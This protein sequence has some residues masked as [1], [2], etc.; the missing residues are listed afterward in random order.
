MY[1]C[2]FLGFYQ[3]PFYQ[4]RISVDRQLKYM[5]H[6]RRFTYIVIAKALGALARDSESIVKDGQVIWAHT[7]NI[8][9]NSA[10]AVEYIQWYTVHHAYHL[11]VVR[12]VI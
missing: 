2:V 1:L 7:G 4:R 11:L 8:L 12:Q 5:L 10:T 6:Y 3:L 9:D